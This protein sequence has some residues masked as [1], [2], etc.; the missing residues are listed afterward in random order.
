MNDGKTPLVIDLH[1]NGNSKKIQKISIGMM[2]MK[3]LWRREEDV[4]F[5]KFFKV[6]SFFKEM[7]PVWFLCHLSVE[8]A[9]TR[10]GEGV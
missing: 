9:E 8:N 3:Q 6:S 2:P 1:G 4:K 5:R 7:L 10:A